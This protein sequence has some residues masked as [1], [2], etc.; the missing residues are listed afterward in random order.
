MARDDYRK[1]LGYQK[2][3]QDIYQAQNP[4]PVRCT[5]GKVLGT[6]YYKVYREELKKNI[7][8]VRS[9]VLAKKAELQK[10][11]DDN[12]GYKKIEKLYDENTYYLE[13][14]LVPSLE[15]LEP[16]QTQLPNESNIQ[17]LVSVLQSIFQMVNDLTKP[18][19]INELSNILE[20]YAP[21]SVKFNYQ[22]IYLDYYQSL[23]PFLQNIQAIT[24]DLNVAL[25]S[26]DDSLLDL[27]IQLLSNLVEVQRIL[28]ET[29]ATLD[30]I[31]QSGKP[32]SDVQITARIKEIE[33][34]GKLKLGTLNKKTLNELGLMDENGKRKTSGIERECCSIIVTD[35]VRR[36]LFDEP[37][38]EETAF[39][40]EKINL[41]AKE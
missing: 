39:K 17:D 4:T 26:G 15:F 30:E 22:K 37:I 38:D 8:Q 20:R 14:I 21:L 33:N 16:F 9:E 23:Y 32:L 25:N 29:E 5:C 31:L 11:Q 10:V 28:V 13:D 3:T 36:G 12:T 40:F 35:A 18:D 41:P 6:R 24:D 34:Q 7:E 19:L 1:S 27:I 2:A